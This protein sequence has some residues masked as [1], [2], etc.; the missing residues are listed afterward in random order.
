MLERSA[1]PSPEVESSADALSVAIRNCDKH[2]I[3]LLCSDGATRSV[4]L[5]AYYGDIQTAAAVSQSTLRSQTTPERWTAP[6]EG[7]TT[8]SSG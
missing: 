8:H 2:M 5:V 6:P 3:D 1:Y 4:G 7:A